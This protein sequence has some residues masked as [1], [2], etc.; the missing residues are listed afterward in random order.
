[1]L[2]AEASLRVVARRVVTP[3]APHLLPVFGGV[4]ETTALPVVTPTVV[5]LVMCL[6]VRSSTRLTTRALSPTM[7][8]VSSVTVCSEKLD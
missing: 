1:M 3:R 2:V 8:A 6:V 7:V 5:R 4:R